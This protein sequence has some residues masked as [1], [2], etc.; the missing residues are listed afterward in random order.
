VPNSA[1]YS[2]TKG[3]IDS[4]SMALAKELGPRNVRVNIV[5]PGMVDTEG[6]RDS[7]FVGSEAGNAGA[8]ATPLAARF[9]KPEGNRT[10]NCFSRLR[11]LCLADRGKNQRIRRFALRAANYQIKLR[12]RESDVFRRNEESAFTGP[13]TPGS[14]C[15]RI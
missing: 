3:A 2:G 4:I 13:V 9:G 7:G 5:A 1:L 15:R 11:R 14:I 6:N 12:S 8:A 10:G